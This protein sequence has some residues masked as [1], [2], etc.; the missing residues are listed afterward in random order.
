MGSRR[1]EEKDDKT[2]VAAS[3]WVDCALR[4]DG[5]LFTPG[6]AI[7]TR[8]LLA[9]LHSRFLD[10]P[11]KG[12][13]D[14]FEKLEGELSGSTAEIYQLMGEVMYV[15]FLILARAGNKQERIERVLGWSPTQVEIPG[16]LID[17]LQ[18]QFID[19][20]VGRTRM[21]SQVGTLIESIEQWKEL[22]LDE[23]ERKLNDPWEFKEFLFSRSYVSRLLVDSQNRGA[24][25]K[26]ILLHIVFPDSFETI[27]LGRKELIADAD[28]FA[29]YITEPTD[30]VDR[31][32]KQIRQALEV[33]LDRNFYF[34]DSGIR[35]MWDPGMRNWDTFVRLAT[36]EYKDADRF[37]AWEIDPKTEMGQSLSV[38]R[39]AVLSGSDDWA[40]LV[41]DGIGGTKAF[42]IITYPRGNLAKLRSWLKES[43]NDALLA[44]R[45]IWIKDDLSIDDRIRS[46]SDLFPLTVISGTGTRVNVT[47]AL[48]MGFD[49]E[50]YPPFRVTEFNRAYEFTGYVKSEQGADEASTYRHALGFLDQFIEEASSRG[51][52]LRHRLDAQ[53]LV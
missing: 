28:S 23:R 32:I 50:K 44:L 7:W 47:S 9:E 43:R 37:A 11:D 52:K 42:P 14:F 40:T 25:Q 36:E 30:D 2:Y 15:Y 29:H 20:G 13:G 26:D 24:I 17:G 3:R 8:G 33:E 49:V 16:D 46:F 4:T 19:L 18:S 35:I 21:P 39:E 12:E 31:K 5:S 45:A 38:A 51:L 48:L 1:T 53:S 6:K 10:Q 27:S 34:Y 41:S 22:E